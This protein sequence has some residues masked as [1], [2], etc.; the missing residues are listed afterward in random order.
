IQPLPSGPFC[1]RSW[2]VL[3]PA[4]RNLL[5]VVFPTNRCVPSVHPVVLWSRLF[6]ESARPT[7]HLSQTSINSLHPKYRRY[8]HRPRHS[9]TGHLSWHWVAPEEDG[10][11]PPSGPV[12]YVSMQTSTDSWPLF[13]PI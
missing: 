4:Y 9:S 3:Q 2:S 1:G 8:F 11:Q 13:V 7:V 6:L 12:C 10:L 5:L